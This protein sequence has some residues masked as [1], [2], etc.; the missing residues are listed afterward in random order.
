MNSVE[1]HRQK[2]SARLDLI[3]EKPTTKRVEKQLKVKNRELL[4]LIIIRLA[5]RVEDL[6]LVR[7]AELID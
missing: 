2:K 3:F 6:Q 7:N 1:C 4:G 5:M